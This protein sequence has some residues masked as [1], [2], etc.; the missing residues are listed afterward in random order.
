MHGQYND[1]VYLELLVGQMLSDMFDTNC[2][3]VL[4]TLTLTADLPIQICIVALSLVLFVCGNN[5]HDNLQSGSFLTLIPR[6]A[7][8][9]TLLHAYVTSQFSIQSIWWCFHLCQF[10]FLYVLFLST[11]FQHR[12]IICKFLCLPVYSFRVHIRF[13]MSQIPIWSSEEFFPE[14]NGLLLTL[15]F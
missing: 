13:L 14:H 5:L 6:K 11:V 2:Y 3:A 15:L 12:L 10:C 7:S 8:S 9:A 4:G 1:L